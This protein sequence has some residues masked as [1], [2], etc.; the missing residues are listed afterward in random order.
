MSD[1]AGA[2]AAVAIEP[3]VIVVMP[4]IGDYAAGFPSLRQRASAVQSVH[5]VARDAGWHGI[6]LG[7][8]ERRDADREGLWPPRVDGLLCRPG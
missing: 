3:E 5:E 4:R 8:G 7:L 2:R 6:L 1:A